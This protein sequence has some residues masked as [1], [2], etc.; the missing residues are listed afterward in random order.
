[1]LQN[2]QRVFLISNFCCVL[3]VIFF[4]LGDSPASEFYVP[5]FRNTLS[6]PSSFGGVSRKDNWDEIS[7]VFVQV[8]VWLKIA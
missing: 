2:I 6:D 5:T 7:R 1:M 4:L 8:K 3:N